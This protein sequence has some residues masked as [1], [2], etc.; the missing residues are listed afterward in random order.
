MWRCNA[1]VPS[2]LKRTSYVLR[3]LHNGAVIQGRHFSQRTEPLPEPTNVL[4]I[5]KPGQSAEGLEMMAQ[6]MHTQ[7]RTRTNLF[8]EP[9]LSSSLPFLRPYQSSE[10]ERLEE[11]IH[12]VITLGGD[13]TLLHVS[14]LFPR[15][16]PPVLS[17]HMGTLGFLIPWH[18]NEYKEAITQVMLGNF[19]LVHRMRL[20]VSVH[21][22]APSSTSSP[23]STSSSHSVA[24]NDVVVHGAHSYLA[25]VRCYI[26]HSGS[27]GARL[28]LT[29]LIGDGLIVSTA[30]GSTAYSLSCGGS[31]VHPDVACL[32]LTPICPVSLSFR[33]LILPS[34][35]AV[36][37]ELSTGAAPLE[38]SVDGKQ[39][40]TVQHN[41]VVHIC[42]AP[43]SF[44]TIVKHDTNTDWVRS[45]T[46][47]LQWNAKSAHLPSHSRKDDYFDIGGE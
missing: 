18:F 47:K 35:A 37:L 25:R 1:F 36:E 17:F 31:M 39:L 30:T 24:L 27:Q 13:G 38:V 21:T 14:K 46:D 28:F 12:L 11:L 41:D 20:A 8:V 26:K 43:H 40:T 22:T 9:S 29:D 44:P 15:R 45:L 2:A 10:S 19:A 23:P 4:I 5:K 6:W 33:P 32:L 16:V 42:T 34:N 7:Y 3:R